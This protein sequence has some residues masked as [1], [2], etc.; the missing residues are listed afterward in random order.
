MSAASSC[1]RFSASFRS[2]VA[3]TPVMKI[4][5]L[6]RP[7]QSA[8]TNVV[9]SSGCSSG[10]SRTAGTEYAMP[11]NRST[12]D[13]ISALMRASSS[14]TRLPVS[15]AIASF[16]LRHVSRRPDGGAAIAEHTGLLDGS[17]CPPRRPAHAEFEQHDRPPCEHNGH[18]HQTRAVRS[19]G[20]PH[21]TEH[22][23]QKESAEP[24][25]GADHASDDPHSAGESLRNELKHGAVA[26][27]ETPDCDKEH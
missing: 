3:P 5:T 18:Q 12:I 6:K 19:C 13:A 15:E 22:R 14:A 16:L 17:F 1:P 10:V 21:G 4:T 8:S 20:V 24:T 25:G 26:H 2:A 9:V 27:T 7:A 23:G 11:P